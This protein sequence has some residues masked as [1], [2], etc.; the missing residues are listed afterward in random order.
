LKKRGEPNDKCNMNNEQCS[1]LRG[2]I[3]NYGVRAMREPDPG[4]TQV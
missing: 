4:G 2:L 1:D 3:I